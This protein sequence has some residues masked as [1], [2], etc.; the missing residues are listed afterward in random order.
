MKK[1]II[2]MILLSGGFI[3]T[4]YKVKMS[5]S[6]DV[7][8]ILGIDDQDFILNDVFCYP[9]PFCIVGPPGMANLSTLKALSTGDKL[10]LAK[11]AFVYA[12]NY[13]N[14]QEFKD[15]YQQKR[16]ELKP[17]VQE[18]TPEQKETALAQIKE[19]EEL[20]SP[21]ILD[22]LPP[23][24]KASVLQ[25][26]VDAKANANG[27]LT[28]D[29]KKQWDELAPE[30]PDI[31]ISRGIKNFLEATRDVDFNATTK[32]NSHSNHQEFTNPAYEQKDDQWKACYR[33]GQE[34]TEAVRSFAQEWYSELNSAG[35]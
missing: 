15:L 18:L 1:A 27:E 28:K 10:N 9:D 12:K 25:M 32:L 22:L 8:T 34:L 33:A 3:I 2:L 14:S 5:V 35:N 20:Y 19:Q 21:D 30:N 11:E 13:C 6:R 17:H 16:M 4:S 31:A 26:I 24:E 23:E 7:L 29:Q